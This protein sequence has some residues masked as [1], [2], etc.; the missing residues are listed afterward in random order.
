MNEGTCLEPQHL[1][2]PSVQDIAT[3]E[4][5]CLRRQRRSI[6]ERRILLPKRVAASG[7]FGP[8]PERHLRAHAQFGL[9]WTDFKVSADTDHRQV[10]AAFSSILTPDHRCT[11]RWRKTI[12]AAFSLMGRKQLSCS[13]SDWLCQKPANSCRQRCLFRQ[14][15]RPGCFQQ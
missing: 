7:F 15:I 8:K 5:C 3:I 14:L 13:Q 10:P 6:C 12:T 2:Y 1:P 9:S 4:Y 11:L